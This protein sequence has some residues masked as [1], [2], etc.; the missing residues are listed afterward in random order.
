MIP[1]FDKIW[2]SNFIIAVLNLIDTLVTTEDGQKPIEEI[3]VGDKVLSENELTGEVAI[4]T[5]TETYVNETD[6]LIH[7]GVNGETI[8]A[9]P[10]HPFYVDK[11]GWIRYFTK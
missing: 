6:E 3:E 10:S 11:L 5:V 9:T 7:I 1:Q 4:K 8:S 2:N